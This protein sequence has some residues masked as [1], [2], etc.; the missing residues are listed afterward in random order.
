MKLGPSVSLVLTLWSLNEVLDLLNY[1]NYYPVTG[2]ALER[3]L[4]ITVK[5]I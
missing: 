1:A 3:I 5:A 4:N 2:K